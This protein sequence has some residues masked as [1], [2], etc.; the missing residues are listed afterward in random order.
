MENELN[1]TK[2]TEQVDNDDLIEVNVKKIKNKTKKNPVNIKVVMEDNEVSRTLKNIGDNVNI[3]DD[4]NYCALYTNDCDSYNSENSKLKSEKYNN[5]MINDNSY[6]SDVSDDYGF[7]NND[8]YEDEESTEL[9]DLSPGDSITNITN[10]VISQKTDDINRMKMYRN[11]ITN[12]SGNKPI[13]VPKP[14]H[15]NMKYPHGHLKIVLGS[16]YSGKS[17]ELKMDRNDW[18]SIKGIRILVVNY[19]KDKRYTNEDMVMT[20]N[21]EGV[22]CTRVECLSEITNGE[23][24]DSVGNIVLPENYDLIL[25]DEGQFYSDLRDNIIH[26]VDILKKTVFIYG[27]DGNFKREK[28]GQVMDL[29]PLCD[30]VIKK[31]AKCMLCNNG[32][33]AL[34]TWKMEDNEDAKIDIGTD[35]YVALC[36][37]HYNRINKQNVTI[38]GKIYSK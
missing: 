14:R 24:Y 4:E 34:F 28:F 11:I 2:C 29:I 33:E 19:S 12:K 8:E 17:S 31:K 27:L 20:H 1:E 26:W 5:T 36:R 35:K 37:K 9:I 3:I 15:K 32:K 6:D 10:Q 38:E 23:C 13:Y 18:L 25:I 16:M 7:D 22:K 30:E 21:K